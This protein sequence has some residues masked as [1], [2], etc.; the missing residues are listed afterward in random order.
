L[1]V[2]QRH[3]LAEIYEAFGDRLAGAAAFDFSSLMVFE[4]DRRYVR[5][6][7]CTPDVGPHAEI[8]V[9]FE[10]RSVGIGRIAE[11]P[12]GTEYNP[13]RFEGLPGVNQM[14][15]VGFHRAWAAPLISDGV[16]YGV[17]T[18]MKMQRGPFPDTDLQFLRQ[19]VQLLASAVRQDEAWDR[20]RR[21]AARSALLA[22]LAVGL[23]MGEPAIALFDRLPPLLG[24]ALHY[25]YVNL[26]TLADAPRTLDLVGHYPELVSREPGP[27]TFEETNVDRFVARQI[28]I[29]EFVPDPSHGGP[30][31]LFNVADLGR[32]VSVL[33]RHNNEPV[34]F[35][36]VARRANVVFSDDE[37]AFIEL[38]GTL[39][40][41]AVANQR[42]LSDVRRG[43]ARADLLNELALLVNAGEPVE[44]LFEPLARVVDGAIGFDYMNLLVRDERPNTLRMVGRRPLI[45]DDAPILY[46]FP[47]A[48]VDG[49][50]KLDRP[51]AQ[52]QPDPE[53]SGGGGWLARAGIRTAMT[54][55]LRQ[56]ETPLGMFS[57][58]RTAL[59]PFG[60]EDLAFVEHV[61]A[62]LAQAVANQARLT[63]A[64]AAAARSELLN[65][66]ALLINAGEN[67]ESL[68]DRMLSLI[69]RAVKFDWIQ[70]STARSLDQ[71]FEIMFSR[72]ELF[73]VGGPGTL[74]QHQ[75]DAIRG[76]GREYAQYRPEKVPPGPGLDALVAAGIARA[77]DV[78]LT[79]DGVVIGNLVFGRSENIP[80][81][82][83]DLA[84][85][86]VVATL[87][88]QAIVAE[89]QL[90]RAHAE[91]ARAE[92]LN[93]LALLVNAGQG[94]ET[95]S[96][97]F[98]ELIG[99]AIEF[100]YIG[101][102][103]RLVRDA[104]FL[105]MFN[106]PDLFPAGS[107]A[108]LSAEAFTAIAAG[109]R[110]V[111][112]YRPEKALQ[113]PSTPVW[114]A[115]GL[116]RMADAIIIHQGE[117]FGLVTL[118]RKENFAYSEEDLRFLEVVA[119]LLANA[120][121][122]QRRVADA[123]AEAHR[124]ALLND[125]AFLVN[126]GEDI[127][128]ISGRF[129]ELIGA[130]V[131]FDYIGL[132]VRPSAT[133]P[134]IGMFGEPELFPVGGVTEI[135]PLALE[136]IS[137]GGHPVAQYAPGELEHAAR[138]GVWLAAGLSRIADALLVYHGETLGLITLGRLTDRTFSD[139]ELRFL[140]VVGTLMAQAVASQRRVAEA[141]G[142]ARR[143][144]LLNE[145]ALLLN[146]GEPIDALFGRV[147]DVVFQVVE[148]DVIAL[149][150]RAAEDETYRVVGIEPPILGPDGEPPIF[151]PADMAR[152]VEIDSSP[153]KF[154]EHSSHSN[155]GRTLMDAGV[156]CATVAALRE[157]DEVLGALCL[158]RREVRPFR[159]E[160]VAFLDVVATLL[161]QSVAAEHRVARTEAEAEEQRFI[162]EI[163][164]AAAR[165]PNHQ[166]LAAAVM[167]PFRRM[168]PRA[169]VAVGLVEGD[170]VLYAGPGG[171]EPAPVPL[172]EH[173]PR[174]I[175]LGQVCHTN[176]TA[177]ND[178][179]ARLLA[180]GVESWVTT[181][182][183]AGGE[184]VG[185]LVCGSRQPGFRFSEREKRLCQLAAQIIGPAIANMRAAAATTLERA[186]YEFALN[187]LS[188]AVWLLDERALP[189]F[190]NAEA[191]RL[192]DLVIPEWRGGVSGFDGAPVPPEI[193]RALWESVRDGMPGR[194][195]L[196][197]ELEGT[198]SWYDLQVVPLNH[199][200]LRLLVVATD[201]TAQVSGE[202][203]RARHRE[204]M[205]RASR[206]AALG[207]MVGG[208]AHELNNPLTAILGFADVIAADS[209]ST[210]FGEEIEV[211]QKEA[212]RA[213]DIVRD[214]LFIARPGPVEFTEV[215]LADA[216]DHI[217]RLRRAD[218]SRKGI[219]V[220]IDD[221]G[222]DR[223]VRGNAH[224][225]IQLLLNLVT[226]AEHAIVG[227]P[228]PAIEILIEEAG[229]ELTLSVADNGAGMDRQTLDRVFEPFFTTK[230]GG[231]TGLGLSLSYSIVATHNGRI[232]V[233]SEPGVGSRFKVSLPVTSEP[234]GVGPAGNEPEAPRR[235]LRVLVV[236][237]EP[238]LRRLCQ[239]LLA[240][241]GHECE[242]ADGSA[243]AATLAATNA[244]DMVLCDYR[245][246]AETAS[247]VVECIAAAAPALV[248]RIVI[249]TGAT[250]DAGVVQLIE[251]YGLRL[252][253]KPYG[254]D[255]LT[256]VIQAVVDQTPT[257]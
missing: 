51:V 173:D 228:N 55:L 221:R 104:P 66:L 39:I 69:G 208:V 240:S 248:G 45:L 232:D 200:I 52:F 165:E 145:L 64:R 41:H 78:L 7:G 110:D 117:V 135:S 224:Q 75:I 134:F 101:L 247:T 180:V 23:D 172:A 181:A 71:R 253:A 62:L 174:V 178:G 121:S 37:R 164:G 191:E 206:L 233:E 226:N 176:P 13:S 40:G 35:L 236:D 136:A 255:E 237:D 72:P 199:P 88:A 223:M 133:A 65:E 254:L 244:F 11:Y 242:T 185:I 217:S 20:A 143:N 24:R 58:G 107:V 139:E 157:R 158:A 205:E 12:D 5:L 212:A 44:V 252:I 179:G 47:E 218:W 183:R 50:M 124:Q 54:T 230:Q 105:R 15:V 148:A 10:E 108:E 87:L 6:V 115:A 188:E 159:P 77:C 81:T 18:V 21:D 231:G 257:V 98:S 31:R 154:V 220:S 122:G 109:G 225:L 102:T 245:L 131:S 215:R 106:S 103:V 144:E 239:R 182:C 112:Q 3:S 38:V 149:V 169:M 246:K 74:D 30:T 190:T 152:A 177:E 138:T 238:N 111:V 193:R 213:R 90:V 140:E 42:R 171:G 161:A 95:L 241:L 43:A 187:S 249:A 142:E 59:H 189:V 26:L 243:E 137:R 84:F 196:R 175:P 9:P 160:E 209:A 82:D 129:S 202:A 94:V 219:H 211:I 91:A 151:S 130:A 222:G 89:Y 203:D 61:A 250:T 97:R 123:R 68:V 132:L 53:R 27:Y 28:T 1:L 63:E 29:K 118:G 100:D 86:E 192:G 79:S 93:Q 49:L 76:G 162:A 235:P 70:L 8:G 96:G 147:R 195:R 214:L 216:I 48:N 14:S 25:D 197:L 126:A 153:Q 127:E 155:I 163:A 120:I 67:L 73:P 128:T 167:E 229:P 83:D 4:P 33:L 34:G 2:N 201:V 60:E 92:L 251:R 234:A 113:T 170:R 168:V 125:L 36:N 210:R 19:A 57:V 204:D 114:R 141:R 22:E 32:V 46:T 85:L 17:F 184:T 146:A 227:R 186:L 99:A 116:R 166:A 194:T 156:K 150:V 56:D 207:E 119:T 256:R 16:S 198:Q 80:F